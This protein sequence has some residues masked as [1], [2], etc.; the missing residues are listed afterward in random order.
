MLDLAKTYN[1]EI[2]KSKLVSASVE[3][4][5]KPA[6][7]SIEASGEKECIHHILAGFN[8]QKTN[9]K[10]IG[11]I[12][13]IIKK[14]D[15]FLSEV[16]LKHKQ[17][18][19]R[20]LQDRITLSKTGES[21]NIIASIKQNLEANHKQGIVIYGDLSKILLS[22]KY[23]IKTIANGLQEIAIKGRKDHCRVVSV[24]LAALEKLFPQ[25][26]KDHLVSILKTKS[27]EDKE[28][29]INAVLAEHTKKHI[30]PLFEK[31]A[32]EKAKATNFT[33]FLS[34]IEKEQKT[35]VDLNNK[36]P[37][38]IYAVDKQNGNIKLSFLMSSA[39]DLHK[40]T[41][42]QTVMAQIRY[43]IKNDITTEDQVTKNLKKSEGNLKSLYTS[44]DKK[45]QV[46]SEKLATYSRDKDHG[47]QKEPEQNKQKEVKI[48]KGFSM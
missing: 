6:N 7:E 5:L 39:N 1:V 4:E 13:N 29:Y 37:L 42:M 25:Y 44:L 26:D 33:E 16:N 36:H 21:K 18:L 40:K 23:D 15:D 14:E 24:E 30:E 3:Q 41:D 32:D 28:Q 12:L 47:I 17:D 9:S 20:N 43:A 34:V 8:Q 38:A 22:S 10:K 48:D 11:Q 2:D 31:Y 46:H 19:D 35:Y 27:R 45:C